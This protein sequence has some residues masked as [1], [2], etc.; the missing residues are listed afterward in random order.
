MPPS[1]GKDGSIGIRHPLTVLREHSLFVLPGRDVP[2]QSERLAFVFLA[3][4]KRAEEAVPE[5]VR[6]RVVFLR[7]ASAH[8]DVC[9]LS[10]RSID[11]TPLQLVVDGRGNA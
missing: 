7:P 3:D 9:V 6:S 5:K 11:F 2:H 4:K 1:D 8:S 10:Q